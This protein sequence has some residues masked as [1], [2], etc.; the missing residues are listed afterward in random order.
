MRGLGSI[1]LWMPFGNVLELNVL[2]VPGMKKIL[3]LVSCMVD[4]Q[5]K[6]AFEGQQ[7][8]ISD[9]SLDSLRTLS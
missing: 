3:L 6:V 4:H 5:I 7:C 1:S 2:F 8:T 9:C